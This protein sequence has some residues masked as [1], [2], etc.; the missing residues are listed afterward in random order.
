MKNTRKFLFALSLFGC[1]SLVSCGEEDSPSS[2]DQRT[3]KHSFSLKLTEEA[4]CEKD[5]LKVF[6]CSLCG[7]DKNEVIPAL[8]H[9]FG[10]WFTES[11]PTCLK[12]EVLAHTC[13]RT[14]CSVKETKDGKGPLG[15]KWGEW[16]TEGERMKRYCERSGCDAFE[17]QASPMLRIFSSQDEVSPF[18]SS[19]DTYLK[20]NNPNVKDY[21]RTDDG[22]E[23]Y[24]VRW[25][26]TFDN[27]TSLRMDYSEQSDFSTYQSETVDASNSTCSLWNLKKAST[28]YLRLVAKVGN[29]E[30]TSSI[31]ALKTASY[32][33][34]VMKIDGIHNV[35]DVGGYETPNGRTVQGMMFRGGALSPST[36]KAYTTIQLS[37]EGKK[38]MS[39]TLQIKTD[40]DLRTQAENRAPDTPV[41]SGLTVSP[42]PNASLHYYGIGGYDSGIANKSGFRK[43]F[44]DLSD[45]MNYPVYIHCTGGADRTGTVSFLVNALLGVSK[46]DLIHDYEYTSFSIYGERNSRGPDYRF[47]E[48]LTAIE[49]YEGDTL[50]KKVESYL[51]SCGVTADEIYNLKAIML[52]KPT[53]VSVQAEAAFDTF[54]DT[55]YQINISGS[56]NEVSTL[57]MNGIAVPFS[58]DGKT[59]TVLKKDFPSSLKDGTIA[60]T[61]VIDGVTYE[62]SFTLSGANTMSAFDFSSGSI[63]LTTASPRATG[64]LVGYDGK[65]AKVYLKEGTSKNQGGTYVFI[66]SYGFYI[67]GEK[68]RVAERSGDTFKESSPRIE[69]F[70][71][72]QTSL[73]K[74]ITLGLSASVLDDTTMRLE[75]YDGANSLGYY[76]FPRV[77]DEISFENAKFEMMISGDVIIATLSSPVRS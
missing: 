26:C 27:V 77:S 30:K 46:E 61:L 62:F 60:G 20:A 12:G 74:G 5:G 7:Y 32:G 54:T 13:Q 50:S 56:F 41:E 29:E 24:K 17:E 18:V 9:D 3:C 71:V 55:K 21:V 58:L 51:L 68:A 33:P 14:N 47:P 59:I 42:I 39:E 43:V 45:P 28:Y 44:S 73:T 23:G 69:A 49:G 8:G 15:H 76:D 66:G 53:K 2:I 4:T 65:M 10:E 11:E 16:I 52:G 37:E 48:F 70:D 25:L 36:D 72:H 6:E 35:R 1:L 40:F 64:N 67:R 38:Y 19:I 63:T 57:S 31:G 22:V 75:L 34:R